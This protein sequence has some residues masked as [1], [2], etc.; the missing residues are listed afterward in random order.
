MPF[1][2]IRRFQLEVHLAPPAMG[3]VFPDKAADTRTARAAV[4]VF[5][6]PGT[7]AVFP[8]LASSQPAQTPAVVLRVKAVRV[9]QQVES[10][11]ADF[12]AKAP[13]AVLWVKAVRAAQQVELVAAHVP[14]R[15][16][17]VV[18]VRVRAVRGA[19]PVKATVAK[20]AAAAVSRKPR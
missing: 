19:Q 12:R 5:R 14:A 8:E 13:E 1:P 11:E 17:A 7:K 20:A 6:V 15:A 3:A 10:A 2:P 4:A 18:V 16:E 9:A